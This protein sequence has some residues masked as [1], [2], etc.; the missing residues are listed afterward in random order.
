[1]DT[2]YPRPAVPAAVFARV[3]ALRLGA[4]ALALATP[5]LLLVA[6]ERLA[7]SP[8]GSDWL[9]LAD[10]LLFGLAAL[11]L[12][13]TVV[14]AVAA[15][16]PRWRGDSLRPLLLFALF[17]AGTVAGVLASRWVRADGWRRV[18]DNGDR[19][20]LAIRAFE[21]RHGAPPETLAELAPEFVASVP[22]TGLGSRPAFRYAAHY[23]DAGHGTWRLWTK[24]P[25]ISH[26]SDLRYLPAAEV[27]EWD[28]VL[29]RVGAWA[30]VAND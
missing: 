29:H 2:T 28:T 5:L 18:A 17:V 4:P 20:V 10:V 8:W 30:V 21:A 1:L 9:V 6:L 14:L 24:L 26:F 27:Q 12:F 16:V 23:A 11:A 15:L 13:A 25:G 22:G 7:F 19:V 3:Q